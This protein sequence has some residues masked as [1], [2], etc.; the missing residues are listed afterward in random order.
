MWQY[1]IGNT[2][3]I[4]IRNMSGIWY[5]SIIQIVCYSDLI[6]PRHIFSAI[7]MKIIPLKV[8]FGKIT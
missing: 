6:F 4:W 7:Q 1:F 3:G 2:G 5:V 8:I